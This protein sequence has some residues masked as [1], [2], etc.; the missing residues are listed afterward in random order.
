MFG[1]LHDL[2]DSV[3][4]ER[5]ELLAG[6]VGSRSKR[7]SSRRMWMAALFE[8]VGSGKFGSEKKQEKSFDWE[9]RAIS[10]GT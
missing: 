6:S 7:S 4:G 3:I 1:T 8:R 10:P 9:W 5:C 2:V